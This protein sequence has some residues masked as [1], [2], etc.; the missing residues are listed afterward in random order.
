[1]RSIDWLKTA[2]D[3]IGWNHS[4]ARRPNQNRMR[5]R[6]SFFE[7]LEPRVLLVSD[8]G[9]APD[10]GAGTATGNYNT[11]A[12]DNGPS[13]VVVAALKMGMSVDI[14]SGTLQNAAANA[15]DIDQSLPDDEDGLNNPAADLAL[16]IGAS[17]TVNV[18]VTNTT[19]IAASLS[20]WI[21]YNNDGVF[22]NVTERAQTPVVTGTS[23]A[24]ATLSFPT[25]PAGFTG[26]TYGAVPP[27]YGPRCR[28]Q[29][30][31]GRC[32]RGSRRL[33]GQNHRTC[34]WCGRAKHEDCQRR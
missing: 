6:Y 10:S 8:F 27:E 15:D 34:C 32:R 16:T 24:I 1:M 13:Y 2:C 26:T 9:D 33:R 11:L 31:W 17:P 22:D 28:R 12:T 30:N 14:D 23:G 19:G 20:G 3:R 25:L 18:I 29:S 21:D 7:P 4:R 5:S